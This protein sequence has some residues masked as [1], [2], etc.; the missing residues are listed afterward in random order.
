MLMN[1]I[2]G[3]ERAVFAYGRAQ[4][5]AWRAARAG[6]RLPVA[7]ALVFM[8]A[9]CS[10]GSV[11][12]M[13]GGNSEAEAKKDTEWGYR[14]R[15]VVVNVTADPG[16]NDY[17]G[18]A[19]SVVLMITQSADPAAF[20]TFVKNPQNISKALG[21]GEIPGMLNLERAY[22]E[23]GSTQRMVLDRVDKA[24]Y[25]G[26]AAAYFEGDMMRNARVF[27]IGVDIK[28]TGIVV[29]NRVATPTPLG[30][31]VRLGDKAL[32]YARP[33]EVT[34]VLPDRAGE[35]PPEPP[36][37]PAEPILRVE[38]QTGPETRMSS[39]S[40]PGYTWPSDV[41]DADAAAGKPAAKPSK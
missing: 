18:L 29:K 38:D 1:C 23:P 2:R 41:P 13:A 8:L 9:G 20:N 37:Q 36:V 6:L 3:S 33:T 28:T 40:G 14:E 21:G 16:L 26:V 22:I 5:L 17:G 24:R 30:L 12:S 25:I 10:F 19:H 11:N 7:L 4:G 34:E 15:G 31:N 27:A 39:D 32:L 35:A